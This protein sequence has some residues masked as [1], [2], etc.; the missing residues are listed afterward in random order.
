MQ[1]DTKYNIDDMIKFNKVTTYPGKKKPEREEHI[2]IVEKILISKSGIS[3]LMKS[4][5]QNWVAEAEVISI[6]KEDA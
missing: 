6:L 1:V 4:S 5:Y 3:Y 2:G